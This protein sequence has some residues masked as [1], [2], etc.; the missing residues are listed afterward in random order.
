[1]ILN[2]NDINF[3]VETVLGTQ[4]FVM[5]DFFKYP[6]SIVSVLEETEPVIWSTPK[7]QP[8]NNGIY[9]HDRGHRILGE[10]VNDFCSKVKKDLNK[11]SMLYENELRTN[12]FRMVDHQFNDYK[13]NYWYP[14]YDVGWSCIVY[15]NSFE[16][17][18]TNFYEAKEKLE[19]A[20]EF[21]NPWVDK[22][23]VWLNA[24]VENKFNRLVFFNA[25]EILHGMSITDDKFF[26]MERKNI[27]IF[28]KD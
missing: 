21:V 14:H 12:C 15:L 20:E 18:A 9:F 22:Q 11:T 23:K 13:N 25:K 3:K 19:F 17:P 26:H 7:S 6:S 5:D 4:V 16:G 1:M 10:V 8:S 2:Y 27:V 28:F 24:Y